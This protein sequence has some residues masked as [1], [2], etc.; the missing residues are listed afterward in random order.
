MVE[1]NPYAHKH[2]TH[3]KDEKDADAV[4]W[5][6]LN[7][8]EFVKFP[9][10]FEEIGDEEIRANVCYVGLCYSDSHSARSHWGPS[11]YPLTPGHEIVGII[12]KVGKNVKNFKVGDRVAYGPFRDMCNNCDACRMGLENACL[13][14][15]FFDVRSTYGEY[16]GGYATAFQQPARFAFKVPK[17]LPS[18]RTPPLLCAGVTVHAP[19]AR[20]AKP[21]DRVAVIGIGG[22]GHL[23]VMYAAKF[24]CHVAA[25]S[26][27]KDKADEIKKLGA[28]EV[29]SSVD[30]AELEKYAS[31]YNVV[32]NTLSVSNEKMWGHY[33]DLTAPGGTFV[34][35]GA[36]PAGEN[37]TLNAFQIIA[38]NIAIVG[39]FVGTR[40]ETQAMLEFSA[41]H[42]ILP[43][44]EFFSFEDFPKAFNHLEKGKPKFRCVVNC[45]EYAKK[46][47]LYKT[48]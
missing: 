48:D 30:M 10:K 2:Y 40:R 22:L 19:L 38:K 34:Q 35:V 18:D 6:F 46:H 5:T 47:G 24:G 44:C 1:K 45:E 41:L 11:N 13:G 27:T 14:S 20:Y 3:V 8:D 4:A 36:P 29:I 39:N 43:M 37:F 31:R 42:N 15:S 16:W 17:N 9:F 32:I 21:G 7:K 33:V 25:L 28:H 12:S 23:A 26:S